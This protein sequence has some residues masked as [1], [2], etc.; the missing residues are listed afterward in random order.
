MRFIL[1][2]QPYETVLASG[3]LQY[4]QDGRATGAVETWQLSQALDGYQLV[5]VDLDARQAASGHSYLYHLLRQA[6]GRP[7]R[8]EYRFWQAG[9]L[10]AGRL[11]FTDTAVIA[12]RTINGTTYEEE[13][14]WTAQTHFWFP[15]SVGLGLLVPFDSGTAVTLSGPPNES[16]ALFQIQT[17]EVHITPYA[18][19]AYRITWPNNERIIW[20]NQHNWPIKMVRDNGLTAVETRALWRI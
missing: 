9:V 11:L 2:E 3:Q 6:N 13:L 15:A 5:R 1:A 12:R 10:L 8:L 17:V 19:A 7:E 20:V 16:A 14:P 4:Q 18:E